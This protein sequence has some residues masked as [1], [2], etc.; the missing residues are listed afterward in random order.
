MVQITGIEKETSHKNND[1]ELL[2]KLIPI[3]K[4]PLLKIRKEIRK[5]FIKAAI[6]G[7]DIGS[8]I[9]VR[10]ISKKVHELVKGM[11]DNQTIV[12][13]LNQLQDNGIVQHISNLKYE[14]KKKIQLTDLKEITEPAWAEFLN[15]IKIEYKDYDPF[16]DK[17]TRK[18]FDHLILDIIKRF[19][20]SSDP[21][22]KKI[23]Q[24]PLENFENKIDHLVNRFQVSAGLSKKMSKILLSYIQSNHP[25]LSKLI[26]ENYYW[27][28]NMHL[29]RLENSLKT[30]D[31][32]KEIKFLFIDTQFLVS[33]LCNTNPL[34][35]L[36][37]AIVK[38][39]V[40]LEIPIYYTQRTQKEMKSFILGTKKEMQGFSKSKKKHG[41]IRSQ[42]IEDFLKKDMTWN[43]Y[44]TIIESW[45]DVV[46]KWNITTNPKSFFKHENEM[47]NID[48]DVFAYVM[49]TLPILDRNR[50]EGRS[51]KD[52]NYTYKL[53][54]IPQIEHDAFC[55]GLVSKIRGDLNDSG[56]KAM[57]PWFVSFD[58]LVSLTDATYFK[59]KEDLGLVI[60]PRS[61]FNFLL[62]YSKLNFEK[63]DES[64]IAEAV[65]KY[66]TC[67][68]E[69]KITIDEYSRLITNKI[70]L[71]QENVDLVKRVLIKSPLRTEL[72][73][74]LKLDSGNEADKIA[75]KILTDESLIN[76]IISERE[77]KE[78]LKNVAK[79][80]IEAE[81]ELKK[82]KVKTT[83]LT[84]ALKEKQKIE[85]TTNVS[86]KSEVSGLIRILEAN[87]AFENNLLEKPPEKPSQKNI[88]GW[89]E[90]IKSTIETS[91]KIGDG[92][93]TL[94]PL[95]TYL[96]GQMG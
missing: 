66:T 60:Q 1:A 33:L 39:C 71:D 41:V 94:L 5:S 54:E 96:L 56:K 12:S 24:L 68:Q 44:I 52:P 64:F 69:T 95:V 63:D 19:V 26:F 90:R 88:K 75:Y 84:E 47:D 74:A 70:G 93:Q 3:T 89:L 27:I 57:G 4:G 34:Y 65:I 91:N 46:K 23:D 36:T 59:S 22:E 37:C 61:L 9:E 13:N 14:I 15:F 21:L 62:V 92:I 85:I 40:N 83:V 53:R 48:N 35:P 49:R 78:K 20:I 80:L 82:E 28:A 8:I 31:L 16:L 86:I 7:F 58:N 43:E 2:I 42:F 73:R 79:R 87:E 76:T 50:N 18:I 38:R 51:E 30:K 45:G 77:T 6:S 32:L 29:L 25:K 10:D 17:N 55:L 11:V 81:E 72:D 67:Y